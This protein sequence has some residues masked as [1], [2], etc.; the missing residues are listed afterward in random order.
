MGWRDGYLY[1]YWMLIYVLPASGRGFAFAKQ[2][3]KMRRLRRRTRKGCGFSSLVK[4]NKKAKIC[5]V[6]HI[7][8]E[9]K[10]LFYIYF[11]IVNGAWALENTRRRPPFVPSPCLYD[12]CISQHQT[13]HVRDHKPPRRGG[14]P[15]RHLVAPP[16]TGFVP[17]RKRTPPFLTGSAPDSGWY[18]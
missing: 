7:A 2:G 9:K 14:G 18:K 12:P 5:F 15:T 16:P 17:V 11:V 6:I 13:A 1:I 8:G 10:I 3:N 4:Q